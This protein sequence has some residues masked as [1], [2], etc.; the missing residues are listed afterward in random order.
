M[1]IMTSLVLICGALLC[2]SLSS[3]QSAAKESSQKIPANIELKPRQANWRMQVAETYPEGQ[4]LKIVFYEQVTKDREVPIRQIIFYDN[5]MVKS[6]MDVCQVADDAPIAKE[7]GSSIVPHGVAVFVTPNGQVERVASY[8]KG[9]LDG[10]MRVFYANGKEQGICSFKQGVRHGYVATYYENG[11]K[12]E[13]ATFADGQIVGDLVRYNENGNRIA[14]IPHKEGAA[15]GQAME[16]YESGALR[17]LRNYNAGQLHSS[18]QTTAAV[19]YGD[20]GKEIIEVQDF[21]NGVPVGMHIQYHP[22]GKESYRVNYKDGKKQGKECF[23][24]SSGEI[25]GEGEYRDGQPIGKIWRKHANGKMAYTALYNKESVLEGPATEFFESG[26]KYKEYY[27]VGDK[28]DGDYK[29]WSDNGQLVVS[30]HYKEGVFDGD[31]MEFHTNGKMKL[32]MAYIKGKRHGRYEEWYAN[33]QIANVIDFID[34]VRTGICSAFYPSGKA[35]LEEHYVEDKLEKDRREW[36]ENGKLKASGQF[37]ED[38]KQGIHREWNETGDLVL[39]V[40]FDN[41]LPDGV[42]KKW[43]GKDRPQQIIGYSQGKKNGK[44]QEFYENGRLKGQASYKMDQLDGD[45]RSWFEDGTPFVEKKYVNGISVGEQKEYYPADQEGKQVLA[46]HFFNDENGQMHGE[47]KTY[48]ANGAPQTFAFYDHGVLE[49]KKTV[50]ND[51]GVLIEEAVYSQGKINGRH[52]QHLDDG[53]EV[54]YHYANNRLEG[55]HEIYYPQAEGQEKVLAVSANYVE[56]VLE[57]EF[58]EYD[59]QGNK[60]AGTPFVNGKKQGTARVWDAK[61][62][63]QLSIDFVDD[64]RHGK[65]FQ[66]FPNGHIF[67]EIAF[68]NDQPHGEEKVFFENG[69]Q[70]SY[71]P[72]VEGKIHGVAQDWN[73]EG[74]LVFEGEYRNGVRH[75]KFNKDYKSEKRKTS[76]LGVLHQIAAM[77]KAHNELHTVILLSDGHVIDKKRKR[78]DELRS[79]LNAQKGKIALYA[80]TVGESNRSMDLELFAATSGSQVLISPTHAAFARKFTKMVMDLQYP[81]AT[82]V[83]IALRSKLQDF[84][85]YLASISTSN[86]PLFASQSCTIVGSA[87]KA[88][89]FTLMIEGNGGGRFVE[90]S[91]HLSL[92]AAPRP[93]FSLASLWLEK[94]AHEELAQFLESGGQF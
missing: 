88:V 45:I 54:I 61:G 2:T 12:Q 39:E 20:G 5:G 27:L 80:A 8:D 73:P 92:K 60:T 43:Y 19:I 46:R 22:N 75:G 91:K 15:H 26:Q 77:P 47:Q 66:Y 71:V 14:L 18:G 76:L 42:F 62:N 70:A 53:R 6:E 79:W 30:Y 38:K 41:D 72:Y 56:G 11:N 4:P 21:Q 25:L 1:R 86:P 57:G 52:F 28:L 17:S 36:Y 40:N 3:A 67:R 63:V 24:S 87:P 55:V 93:A 94:S 49:G 37:H 74:V 64:K 13:E 59:Q 65:F 44:L 7:S 33:G 29:E 58:Q 69:Q 51:E 85:L 83:T 50:W 10:Q 81:L 34:G 89:D 16:W 48:H 23:F 68:K 82:D 31:Q 90:I 9:I 32:R 78:E 84:P 35:K